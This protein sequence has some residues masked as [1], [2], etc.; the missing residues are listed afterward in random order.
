MIAKWLTEPRTRVDDL[1][2]GPSVGS[3]A[4]NRRSAFADTEDMLKKA[5]LW[6]V[7]L[8]VFV[9]TFVEAASISTI[10]SEEWD[11]GVLRNVE[12]TCG[13]LD[14][15]SWFARGCSDLLLIHLAPLALG[16]GVL[17]LCIY[18]AHRSRPQ[19]G[20]HVAVSL[21]HAGT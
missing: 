21:P 11:G 10:V 3:L 14:P 9:L 2:P 5:I 12:A 1:G 19:P 16:V 20:R 8:A 4:F 15:A 7:G 6:P 17:G 18:L 13:G